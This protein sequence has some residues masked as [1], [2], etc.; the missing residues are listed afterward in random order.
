MTRSVRRGAVYERA[1][2]TGVAAT[3]FATDF[4]TEWNDLSRSL[5]VPDA[6]TL[7][8]TATTGSLGFTRIDGRTEINAAQSRRYTRRQL[9]MRGRGGD[10]R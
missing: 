7:T 2:S 9:T 6:A 1:V 8:P 3:D 10:S 4:A 5:G